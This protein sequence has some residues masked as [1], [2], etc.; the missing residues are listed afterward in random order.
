[1]WR[2]EL[3]A[4]SLAVAS[5]SIPDVFE[6]AAY[7]PDPNLWFVTLFATTRFTRSP[8]ALQILN[9]AIACAAAA[10]V[11]FLAPFPFAQRTLMV[12]GYFLL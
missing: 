5:T 7:E 11:L 6:R 4:W 2:D 1:M 9:W 10:T 3:Q 12:S 8:A